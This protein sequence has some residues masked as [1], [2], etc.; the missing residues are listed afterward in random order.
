MSFNQVQLEE[1]VRLLKI[2]AVSMD[3]LQSKNFCVI[4]NGN[5]HTNNTTVLHNKSCLVY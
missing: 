3:F 1:I 2:D 4:I 5:I